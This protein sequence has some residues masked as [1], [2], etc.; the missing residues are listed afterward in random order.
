M[1]RLYENILFDFDGTIMDTSEGIRNSFDRVVAVYHPDIPGREVYDRMMAMKEKYPE[2]TP[3]TNDKVYYWDGVLDYNETHYDRATLRG[4]AAFAAIL[5]DAG[6]GEGT[7][8]RKKDSPSASVIRVGDI[9]RIENDSHSV[10]VLSTEGDFFTIAE[11]NFNYSVHWGR[12]IPKTTTIY[13]YITR[14]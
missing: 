7:P 14:W 1:G 6:F 13:Y 3:F 5:S 9:I 8:A 10:M 11:G 12:R 4:C 2:G